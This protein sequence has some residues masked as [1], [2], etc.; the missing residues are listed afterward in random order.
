MARSPMR[1]ARVAE[2]LAGGSL[3]NVAASINAL[4]SAFT[5]YWSR[6][7][8]PIRCFP[9]WPSHQARPVRSSYDA[10]G[11]LGK[12]TC[13]A[14][15]AKK[16]NP[17]LPRLFGATAGGG[18]PMLVARIAVGSAP[19]R[20]KIVPILDKVL[21]CT[22]TCVYLRRSM[23]NIYRGLEHWP[24]DSSLFLLMISATIIIMRK[25]AKK[26]R[27]VRPMRALLDGVARPDKTNLLGR[28]NHEF[29][30]PIDR[31]VYG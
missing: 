9:L 21:V 23:R 5:I 15:I 14:A 8:H 30:R 29:A 10:A 11:A 16:C 24:R 18:K 12:L 25:E 17:S 6:A 1:C 4:T 26:R 19:R 7:L 27:D 31:H 13:L 20:A 28:R 3:S 22:A 2:L